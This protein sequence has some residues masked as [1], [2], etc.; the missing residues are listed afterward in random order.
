MTT[1]FPAGPDSVIAPRDINFQRLS[2]RDELGRQG[3]VN[4]VAIDPTDASTI[5]TTEAPTSGGNS[6]FRTDD[7]GGSWWPIVDGL[8]QSDPGGVNPSCIAVHPLSTGYVYLGTFSGRVYTSPNTKGATWGAPFNIGSTVFKIVVDPRNAGDP[9][10]T[11]VYAACNNGVYRS[12]DGGGSFAQVLS[13][14]LIDFAARIPT[15]GSTADFYAGVSAGGVFYAT[16]PTGAASW[17]NLNTLAGT[18][19]PAVI[20]GTPSKP[21]GNFDNMRIDVCRLARRAY[22]WFFNTVCDASGN[23]CNEGTAALFTAPNP[24]G[25][26]TQIAMTS[27]PQPAYGLYDSSFAVAPNSPGDG[28]ADI[29]LFGSIHLLRSLDSGRTWI[30]TSTGGDE[31]HDD[32]HAFAFFPATPPAG[33][34]PA[35]YIGC[36]GGLGVS[37]R[38]ADPTAVFPPKPGDADELVSYS[39]TAVVQNYSHGKQSSAIYQYGSD[40]TIGALGYIGCQDTGLNAG[41][42]SLLWRGA[43]NADGGGVAA[44]QGADGVKV[45]FRLGAGFYMYMATDKGEYYP[46]WANVTLAGGRPVDGQS[47]YVVDPNGNCLAGIVALNPGTSIAAAVGAGAQ[48]VTPGA[49]TFIFPGSLLAIG[50][51][52]DATKNETVKVSAVAATTFTATFA[53]AH[54]AGASI[55]RVADT[56]VPAAIAAGVQTVTPSAMN[57][58]VTEASLT[59]DTGGSQETVTVSSAAATTFTA[60]FGQTHAAGAPVVVNHAYLARVDQSANAKPIS[61]DFGTIVPGLVAV[62]PT[63]ADVVLMVTNDQRLWQTGNATAGTPAW[64]EVTGSKPTGAN[65]SSIA[66]DKAGNIYLL[67]NHPVSSGDGP[68][69]PLFRISGGNFVPVTCTSLPSPDINGFGRL[70]ADPVQANTLYAAHDAR[71]FRLTSTTAGGTTNWTDISTGLPGQWVYDL[72]VG[73]IANGGS[74]KVLL[75]ASVPT[76]GVWEVDVTAGATDQALGLYMRDNVLD[77][78]W[79][80]TSPDGVTNPYDPTNPG[81]ILYH[82]QC[83]DIKVDA[84]QHGTGSAPDF[85]QTDPEGTLPLSHVLFDQLKDNS[86]HLPGS[87]QAMVHVQVR[88]RGLSAANNVRVWALYC[89]ASAGVPALSASPSFGDNFPFWDQFLVTGQIVPILPG[90]SPWAPIGPPQTL[91]GIDPAH[92]QVASWNRTVPTLPSGDPGHYCIVAFVHSS[93][94]PINEASFNVD[95]MTP[96]N[97]Q[98]GQKNLHVGPPLPARSAGGG[99]GGGGGGG[100]PRGGGA[101]SRGAGAGAGPGAG[102]RPIHLMREY[103]EFHNPTKS[104]REATLAIDL[105]GLPPELRLSFLLTGL[106]TVQPLPKSIT[107]IVQAGGKHRHGLGGDI[108]RWIDRIEDEIEETTGELLEWTGHWMERLGRALEDRPL[109]RRWHSRHLPE[110]EQT[111]Y[112]ALPSARIEIAGVRIP[113]GGSVAALLSMQNRGALPEGGEYLFHVQQLVGGKVVGGSAYKVRIAGNK[114]AHPMVTLLD[115]GAEVRFLEELEREAED[116]RHL[117]PWMENPVNQAETN[118]RKSV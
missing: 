11:V 91:S 39:N 90:D 14:S 53:N 52:T 81:A 108:L 74:P 61:Q 45:W 10:T 8:Q 38:I 109:S 1:W 46:G 42:S 71:V 32:Y 92:P 60:T 33:T 27:P 7:D 30:D 113:A 118:L 101:G 115:R 36:D 3:L 76:R 94:S 13:G 95:E 43:F 22:V 29:L 82:Y 41:D 110:F 83:A 15:D 20:A 4:G 69:T 85:F 78:G 107:G 86:D 70:V 47:N 75:R 80:P 66:I 49:M 63:S 72:W 111:V 31:Y 37:T 65:M 99:G 18:G 89:N 67:F 117:P 116:N 104:S 77:T 21:N 28:N 84:Q 114:I 98:V 17:T 24:T 102:G 58:I 9:T 87:D 6:A 23:N 40:P 55:T 44:K 50:D 19:L 35:T 106:D 62:S 112:T 12:N 73:N 68:T 54:G 64:N 51:P 34:I 97:K 103:V 57:G 5:Y 100:A 59:I 48:T 79:L 2:R 26:W 96:L 93:G 88:N 105:R 25:A 16:N 56:S